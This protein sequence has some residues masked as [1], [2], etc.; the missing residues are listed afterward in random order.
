ARPDVVFMFVTPHHRA[1]F[2]LIGAGVVSEL[3]PRHALGCSGGGVIGAGREAE[4]VPALSVTAAVLPNVEIKPLRL[5]EET[6]PDPDAGP[7]AWEDATG[8]RAPDNP[9]FVLL[10]DPFSI[11]TDEMLEGLDFAYP[12]SVKI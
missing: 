12:K 7:R 9:Q 4:Q 10:A 5:E 2:D 11:H 6:L 8:I 1:H 3:N